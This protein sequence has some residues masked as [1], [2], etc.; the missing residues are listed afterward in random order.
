MKIPPDS[1]TKPGQR[2]RLRGRDRTGT[3]KNYVRQVTWFSVA[4]DDGKGPFIC[5]QNELQVIHEGNAGQ[6]TA[7]KPKAFTAGIV[8]WDYK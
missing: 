7:P 8:L 5:H 3:V 2:V 1:P 4:W 6:I